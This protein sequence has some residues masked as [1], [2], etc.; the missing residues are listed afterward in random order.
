VIINELQQAQ[1][2]AQPLRERKNCCMLLNRLLGNR[3]QAA[4]LLNRP[5]HCQFSVS[6]WT[7][8]GYAVAHESINDRPR[9]LRRWL[10]SV[11]VSRLVPK[12]MTLTFVLRSYQG[13]VKECATFDVE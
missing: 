3:H 9:R 8:W 7:S 4:W 10:L 2:N 12:W 6:L 13:H 1:E 11:F 5:L